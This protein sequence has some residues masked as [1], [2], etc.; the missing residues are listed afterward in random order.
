MSE[1]KARKGETQKVRYAV[2]GLGYISQIA[3]W[4]AFSHSREYSEVTALVSGDPV[5]LKS[6][7]RR[8][9][10]A[11]TYSYEQYADCLA[12]GNI[13]AVYIALPNHMHRAYAEPAARAGIHILCE[14]PHGIRR[15]RMRSHD[16][17]GRKSEGQIDDRL[18]AALRARQPAGH[19]GCELG[20]DWRTTDFHF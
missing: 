16:R 1:R 10:I 5:K 3:V 11:H 7:A 19:P 9:R 18:S 2:V 17:R 20:K 13:D 12:S 14:K 15:S 4:P 8:Y 6:L